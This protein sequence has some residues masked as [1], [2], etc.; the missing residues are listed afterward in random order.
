M[1][2]SA[3]AG[4]YIQPSND[5]GASIAKAEEHVARAEAEAKQA[6]KTAARERKE[7]SEAQR[8]KEDAEHLIVQQQRRREKQAE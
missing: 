7:A 5:V 3:L 8:A 2:E 1:I 6:E 4:S